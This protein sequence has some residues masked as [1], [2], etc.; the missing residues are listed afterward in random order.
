METKVQKKIRLTSEAQKKL[1][2]QEKRRELGLLIDGKTIETMRRWIKKTPERF[3]ASKSRL[4]AIVKV[5]GLTK[6]E[7]FEEAN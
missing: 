7:L 4:K 1:R 2:T 5:S 3:L 6:E